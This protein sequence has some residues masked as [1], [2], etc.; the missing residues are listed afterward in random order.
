MRSILPQALKSWWQK[1][2]ALVVSPPP[3]GALAEARAAAWLEHHVGMRLVARNWRNPRDRRE[4]IDL[5]MREGP[6][7]VFVEVKGRSAQARVP[8]LHA[9]GAAKRAILRRAV[10]AYLVGLREPDRPLRFDV[11]EVEVNPAMAAESWPVH[12]FP[13]VPLFSADLRR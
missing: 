7:L 2:S 4:E 13:G 5:I 11:V 1:L 3:V 10:R 9:V 8:G 12:H 6:V